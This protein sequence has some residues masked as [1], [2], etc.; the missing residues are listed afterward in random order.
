MVPVGVEGDAAPQPRVRV[1]GPLALE[2]LVVVSD[3]LA[4]G[5]G[6]EV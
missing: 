4:K 5:S 1:V 3:R 6:S 2:D